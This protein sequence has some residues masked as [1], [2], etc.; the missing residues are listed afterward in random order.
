MRLIMSSSY[1]FPSETSDF[2]SY[3]FCQEIPACIS[4]WATCLRGQRLHYLSKR[5]EQLAQRASV[6]VSEDMI[7]QQ[8]RWKNF[9]TRIL[10]MNV[11][12]CCQAPVSARFELYVDHKGFEK[13]STKSITFATIHGSV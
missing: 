7:L 10:R 4:P 5:P 2:Y 9:E 1:T 11:Q 8:H 12:F 3:G 13:G 6:F